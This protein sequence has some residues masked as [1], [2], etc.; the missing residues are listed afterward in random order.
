MTYISTYQP[1]GT[2]TFNAA[3]TAWHMLRERIH[4]MR[5]RPQDIPRSRHPRC[6][7]VA[8]RTID[9]QLL[10]HDGD[11]PQVNLILRGWVWDSHHPAGGYI[12]SY[13]DIGVS[14]RNSKLH[15][16]NAKSKSQLACHLLG[17]YNFYMG[18]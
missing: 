12:P 1:S 9:T 18:I 13:V 17:H 6:A 11:C 5:K 2:R 16:I 15:K 8:S 10:P 4:V 3:W 7:V 14:L